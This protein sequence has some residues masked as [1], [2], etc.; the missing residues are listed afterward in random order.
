MTYKFFKDFISRFEKTL[1]ARIEK[2]VLGYVKREAYLAEP[3]KDFDF[4]IFIFTDGFKKYEIYNLDKS[5]Y[6]SNVQLST[7]SL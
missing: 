7:F 5:L 6:L 1:E 3:I 2:K 4:Y